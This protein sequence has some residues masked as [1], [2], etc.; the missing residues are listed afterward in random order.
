[1][2][3]S[4]ETRSR[5]FWTLILI[6]VFTIPLSSSLS[7]KILLVTT[8]YWIFLTIY[9]R[10]F[11]F[12][13][14][15][16]G[17]DIYLYLLILV[18][19][20]IYTDDMPTGLRV[21]ETSLSFFVIPIL[22]QRI[23]NFAKWNYDRIFLSF[24]IGLLVAC[25]ICLG[26]A[27]FLF[28][29]DGNVEVFFF[30]QLTSV[31]RSHPTYLAYYIIFSIGYVTYLLFTERNVMPVPIIISSLI[32][33]FVTLMLTGG[34]TSF[35]SMLLVFSFFILKYLQEEKTRMKTLTF[36][37]VAF[38][39]IG[40][41]AISSM[42]F[43]DKW[44]FERDDSWE[45]SVLW[46]SAIKATPGLWG[47]GTGDYRKSL[48]EYYLSHNLTEFADASA[49]SH[50]QF[51]EILFSNGLLGLFSFLLLL[52]RPLY[53]S[54]RR[55]NILGILTFFPFFIYG[56]TEVFLG[57]YQGV[58]FFAF[59]HQVFITHYQRQAPS[60]TLKNA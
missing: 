49:N 37:M 59:L 9:E 6:F 18:I 47:V 34:R 21:L 44:K 1:M 31:I 2:L 3:R 28:F 50:N 43:S 17:W 53:L 27:L 55:R 10:D 39:T 16:Q 5:I 36:C 14:F 8:V 15:L 35:I 56:M 51:I 11:S 54:G 7:V 40:M 46:E 19:G 22:F 58:V 23:R 30:Y 25:L 52:I 41:F 45:R 42:D 57:R 24:T 60:F 13:F 12:G 48:N 33:L 32:F 29:T 4:K 20:L 26:H 38:M